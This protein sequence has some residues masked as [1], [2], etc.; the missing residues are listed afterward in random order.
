[1]RNDYL[2]MQC[3]GKNGKMFRLNLTFTVIDFQFKMVIETKK[4][5]LKKSSEHN[6]ASWGFGTRPNEVTSRV[7]SRSFGEFSTLKGNSGE[8]K[9]LI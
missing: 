9:G 4:N 7:K 6:P 1:M 8:K 3:T 2:K 5:H